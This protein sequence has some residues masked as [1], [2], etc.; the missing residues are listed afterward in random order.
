MKECL[1]NILK[2]R[3]GIEVWF[4]YLDFECTH[5]YLDVNETHLRVVLKLLEA[6]DIVVYA[7]DVGED[8]KDMDRLVYSI[9]VEVIE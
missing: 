5:I 3:F 6:C 8:L 2:E 4:S 7:Y 1:K 9:V